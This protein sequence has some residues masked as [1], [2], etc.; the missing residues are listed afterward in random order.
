[1]ALEHCDL[2]AQDQDLGV[3]G[4]IGL[5]EQGQQAEQA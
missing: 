1:V 2:V 4:Q 3:F 5:G